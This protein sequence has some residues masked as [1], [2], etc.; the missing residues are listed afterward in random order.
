VTTGV[1]SGIIGLERIRQNNWVEDTESLYHHTIETEQI[2][3]C[4]LA[5]IRANQAKTNANLNKTIA[6]MRAC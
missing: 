4:L 5:K 3:K 2:M 1:R 6:E